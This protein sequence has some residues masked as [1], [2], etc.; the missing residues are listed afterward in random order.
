MNVRKLTAGATAAIAASALLTGVAFAGSNSMP[1]NDA[2]DSASASGSAV[3]NLATTTTL[4]GEA[5]GDAISAAAQARGT[6]STD[7]D[8]DH[9][10]AN[11]DADDSTSASTDRDA[12]GDMVSKLATTTTLTGEA[13]GDA[14]S[15]AAKTGH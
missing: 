2:D 13:K 12:H 15:A 5:K 6:S 1:A 9:R 4:T 11:T 3:A 14:I 10:S 8:T 7:V